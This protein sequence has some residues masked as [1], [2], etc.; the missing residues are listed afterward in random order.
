[1]DFDQLVFRFVGS[2]WGVWNSLSK[3]LKGSNDCVWICGLVYPLVYLG[4]S[5][6]VCG[7]FSFVTLYG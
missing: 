2:F 1:M 3:S 7:S 4:V 6:V 5:V